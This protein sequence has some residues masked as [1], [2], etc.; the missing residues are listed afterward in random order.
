MGAVYTPYLGT[1]KHNAVVLLIYIR[2]FTHCNFA[3]SSGI[4][5][6]SR[7]FC[8]DV[9]SGYHCK[10][11]RNVNLKKYKS[12]YPLEPGSLQLNFQPSILIPHSVRN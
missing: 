12:Y 7:H 8:S 11:I 6:Y 9:N 4:F 10:N 5:R 3:V 1:P 2:L